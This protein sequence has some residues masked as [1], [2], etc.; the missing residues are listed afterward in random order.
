MTRSKS[1]EGWMQ[2]VMHVSDSRIGI[3]SGMIPFFAGIGMFVLSFEL[4]LKKFRTQILI[5]FWIQIHTP[6]I[7]S[8]WLST[9]SLPIHHYQEKDPHFLRMGSCNTGCSC[10][11]PCT[12]QHCV[13]T[14]S[15]PLLALQA[16]K[17][18]RLL[19]TGHCRDCDWHQKLK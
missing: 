3:N 5:R 7:C 17:M 16:R 10:D 15:L 8:G 13:A 19:G 2:P 9:I 12:A 6:L 1:D 18:V 4:Q 11:R 14:Q